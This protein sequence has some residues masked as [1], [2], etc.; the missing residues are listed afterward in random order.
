MPVVVPNLLEQARLSHSFFHQNARSLKRQFQLPIQQARDI[1]LSC[2]D[3]QRVAPMPSKEGANPRGLRAN[4]LWQTDVTHILEFGRLKYVHVTVDTH[5]PFLW[6]TTHTS[7]KARDV[8]HHWLVCFAVLGMPVTI[9]TD[10]GPA[11]FSG[12]ECRFLNTW[13][14]SHVTGIPRSPTGQ[15]IVE[16]SHHSLKDM[17]QKQRKGETLLTP[18]ERL[19]KALYVLN[20]L[21]CDETGHNSS[22]RQY[23]LSYDGCHH[24]VYNLMLPHPRSNKHACRIRHLGAWQ[25]LGDSCEC[26]QYGHPVFINGDAIRPLPHLPGWTSS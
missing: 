14:I 18:Q 15:A 8:T 4:K 6:A 3:C 9:K 5:S 21:N 19:H 20:F 13:G 11:Y 1:I 22:E 10:N 2:P 7:E 23:E 24:D 26:N 16:R 25:R 12:R 17:L